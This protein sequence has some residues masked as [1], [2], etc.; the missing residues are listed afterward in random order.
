MHGKGSR[1]IVA[2]LTTLSELRGIPRQWLVGGVISLLEEDLC[3]L[4]GRFATQIG[5]T[6]L[7]DDDV[8]IVL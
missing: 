7:G 3:T 6:L 2:G 5:D 8:D 4:A 1:Q